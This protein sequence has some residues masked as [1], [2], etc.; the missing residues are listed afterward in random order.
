MSCHVVC[1]KIDA[2]G[3][4]SHQGLNRIWVEEFSGALQHQASSG[5]CVF[6]ISMLCAKMPEPTRSHT[7][8][9]SSSV[10]GNASEN[11]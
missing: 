10:L 1:V 11:S 3:L 9:T 7:V 5:L 2:R 4:S 8:T 6:F